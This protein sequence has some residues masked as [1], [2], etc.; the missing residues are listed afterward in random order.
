MLVYRCS[1][2]ANNC[3]FCLELDEKYGCGWCQK[4][5]TCEVQEQCQHQSQIWYNRQQT[6]PNPRVLDFY[7]KSGPYEGGTNLT[8]E[9]INLGRSFEDIENGVE[10]I[11]ESGGKTISR[12]PCQPFKDDYVKTSKIKCRLASL[13]NY[14]F[15]HTPLS[16]PSGPIVVKV[17]NEY[18]TRSR[19]SYT[20]VNPKILTI[21]PSKGPVSG[22]TLLSI[23]GLHMN[24]GSSALAFLGSLPC[25]ITRRTLNLAECVTSARDHPGEEQVTVHFDDGR[26]IFEYYKYLYVE[27]PR[28]ITVY[29]GSG[30]NR[31][32]PRGIPS[33]GILVNVEGQNMNFIQHPMIYVKVS[34]G[35]EFTSNCSADVSG[36]F[37]KCDSP[38]VAL[39]KLDYLDFSRNSEK[40][41]IELDYGFVMDG[42]KSVRGLTTRPEKP[43]G[44][45]LMY[46]QPEFQYFSED[47]GVRY[48]RG[49][50]LTITVMLDRGV[51]IHGHKN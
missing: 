17:L 14:T 3:G 11:N 32:D 8:I 5:D 20:F 31:G 36:K 30:T 23:E 51:T 27:D 33:G 45:F 1:G 41:Y 24:A 49:E 43:F 18:T 34:D 9:G 13:R 4:T 35:E 19:E 38:Q 21:N 29:S 50:Y 42:V 40:D 28:I 37:M 10:I 44:K 25:N 15:H 22:G 16:S 46:R 48:Y 12:I 47:K 6:C 7:P 39:D 26:R 2:L